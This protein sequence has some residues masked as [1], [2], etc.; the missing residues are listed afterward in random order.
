MTRSGP[1]RVAL[2]GIW[3]ETNTFATQR[4][5][6]ADVAARTW[7]DGDELLTQAAGTQ[8]VL[9]GVVATAEACGW[10][11]CPLRFAAAP[12]GGRL[13]RGDF[14]TLVRGLLQRLEQVLPVDGVLLV[15]HG[16]LM[17][18][19]F[20]SGDAELLRR[21]R[22]LVG[23]RVPIATVLDFHANLSADLLRRSDIVVAYDTYPHVDTAE[24]GAEAVALLDRVLRREVRP[25]HV[26][27]PLPLLSPLTRQRTD[28]DLP[29]GAA[30]AL[31]DVSGVLR[32]TVCAGFPYADAH[33]A[34]ASVVVTVDA[35][36]G[37]DGSALARAL[38]EALWARRD[39]LLP[40]STPLAAAVEQA[41]SWRGASPLLLADVADNPGAGASGSER[42]LL[43]ALWTARVP[44]CVVAALHAPNV[45]AQAGAVGVGGLLPF[46]MP[47]AVDGNP[48]DPHHAVAATVRWCGDLRV[49]HTSALGAGAVTR[50]GQAALLAL[51]L[52]GGQPGADDLLLLVTAQRTQVLD[53]DLL[54]AVGIDPARQ[55]VLAL[56]SSVHLRAGF[57]GVS[58]TVLEVDGPGLAP[59]DLSHLPYRR[60]RRP[61][62]PL[63]R[64]LTDADL[65]APL[66][67]DPGAG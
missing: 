43:N 59:L 39:E 12:A 40:H 46:P 49:R 17:V 19:G 52:P 45:V 50:G 62:W 61:I 53:A 48:A 35:S 65:P 63:E 2:G 29:F 54:R 55:R 6:L 22:R 31:R 33:H 25:L 23:S 18:E 1:P 13:R 38:S 11:L 36:S 21:V 4:T 30:L 14:E 51:P 47:P 32:A 26:F 41:R 67:I 64:H 58:D 7:L 16:A 24:R 34:G 3:H 27:Q 20:A 8:T 28:P 57:A 10:E 60:L 15:Q 56:K 42:A 5:E 9:G 37:V 66:V 44:G